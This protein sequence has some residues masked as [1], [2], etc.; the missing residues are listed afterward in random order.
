MRKDYIIFAAAIPVVA[1][2]VLFLNKG[3]AVS[4]APTAATGQVQ[5]QQASSKEMSKMQALCKSLIGKDKNKVSAKIGKAYTTAG[6]VSYYQAASA[7]VKPPYALAI[8]FKKNKV[9]KAEI[10]QY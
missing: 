1:I 3:K 5:Q 10:T 4:V 8:T 9:T 6:G 7:G 2:V